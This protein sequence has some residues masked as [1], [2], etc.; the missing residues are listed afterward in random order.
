MVFSFALKA[1]WGVVGL[2]LA[3]VLFAVLSLVDHAQTGDETARGATFGFLLMAGFLGIPGGIALVRA[4]ARAKH[5]QLL[6]LLTA[7]V[8]S[9]DA[10]A[11]SK[12]AQA[13]DR[14]EV[15]TEALLLQL[16]EADKV[17]LIFHQ[18]REEYL[19]RGRIRD[20]H[21]CLE[22]CSSCGAQLKAQVIFEGEEV[23]CEY[24]N[25]PLRLKPSS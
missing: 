10:I 11:L 22:K 21:E 7:Y 3:F 1:L 5:E 15:E 8:R 13:V 2:A 14:T 16:I 19:H 24:C 17:D 20:A 4:R 18:S 25:A 6:S 23:S 9:R 12:V